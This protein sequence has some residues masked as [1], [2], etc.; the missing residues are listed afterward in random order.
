M[1]TTFPRALLFAA[2][3]LSA[4]TSP[5]SAAPAEPHGVHKADALQARLDARVAAVD[6]RLRFVRK[7]G[8]VSPAEVARMEKSLDWVRSDSRKYVRRQ[9]FLSAGESASYNR[10]LNE[11]ERKLG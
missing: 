2:L 9:G 10:T 5:A 4:L 7:E 1:R 3:G 11:I 8:R 6:T